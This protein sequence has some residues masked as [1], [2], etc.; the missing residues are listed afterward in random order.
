M[1]TG[2]EKVYVVMA[3][4]T[5]KSDFG[6]RETVSSVVG[7]FTTK[8]DAWNCVRSEMEGL[9]DQLTEKG[10]RVDYDPSQDPD[11]SILGTEDDFYEM[12]TLVKEMELDEIAN[13]LE[14][15]RV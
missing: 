10:A 7:V 5:D 2:K 13:H 4:M 1:E 11:H 14:D 8:G 6:L 12:E 9:R 3:Y 15:M